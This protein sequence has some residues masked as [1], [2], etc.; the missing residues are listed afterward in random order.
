MS[1]TKIEGGNNMNCESCIGCSPSGRSF[2]TK[3]EMLEM[4]G[5]YKKRLE[6]EAKGVAEKIKEIESKK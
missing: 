3:E 5:E 4:L 1:N 2:L 6:K